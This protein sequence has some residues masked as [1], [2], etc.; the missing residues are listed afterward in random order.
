MGGL[1]LVCPNCGKSDDHRCQDWVVDS[2]A[3]E[4]IKAMATIHPADLCAFCSKRRASH[5]AQCGRDTRPICASCTEYWVTTYPERPKPVARACTERAVVLYDTDAF[6]PN[7][8]P[9]G[10]GFRGPSIP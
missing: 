3:Q 2:H 7:P 8:S 4:R 10:H 1:V 6:G 9:L 5:D